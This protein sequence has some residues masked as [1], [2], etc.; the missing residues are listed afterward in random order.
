MKQN[1]N[2]SKTISTIHASPTTALFLSQLNFINALFLQTK[3]AT[4]YLLFT[5]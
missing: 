1:K 3:P 4:N 5:K 2:K